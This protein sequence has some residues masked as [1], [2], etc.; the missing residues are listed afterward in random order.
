MW[1]EAFIIALSEIRVLLSRKYCLDALSYVGTSEAFQVLKQKIIQD[2]KISKQ[3]ELQ[4]ML[5]G[6][7][8]APRPTVDH[9]E[10]VWVG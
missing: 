4:R 8:S 6:L 5:L 10:A 3:E 1:Q 9:I 7:A 2:K